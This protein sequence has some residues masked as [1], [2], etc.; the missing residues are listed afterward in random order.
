[1]VYVLSYLCLL[2]ATLSALTPILPPMYACCAPIHNTSRFID[3]N[4]PIQERFYGSIF[5]V[6]RITDLASTSL[7]NL[8]SDNTH[9]D[10]NT[11]D[12]T[13][14]NHVNVKLSN[15]DVGDVY[16]T[17]VNR[18]QSE[19]SDS[20]TDLN[21]ANRLPRH[22]NDLISE[23]EVTT[24][25]STIRA[26]RSLRT[27]HNHNHNNT[28]TLQHNKSGSGDLNGDISGAGGDENVF[29]DDTG[30]RN[31][32]STN[33]SHITGTSRKIQMYVSVTNRLLQILSDGTVNGT[34]DDSIYTILQ[35]IPVKVGQLRIQ[36]V[37]SCQYLCIDACGILYGSRDFNNE[38]C[39]FNEMIE[40]NHYNT[41]SSAKYSNKNRTMY[42]ALTKTGQPRKV[43]VKSTHL[44]KMAAYAR[45]LTKPVK[46]ERVDQLEI[47]ML[48]ILRTTHPHSPDLLE[49]ENSTQHPL[50]HHASHQLLCPSVDHTNGESNTAKNTKF[51]CRKRKKRKKKRRKPLHS[52]NRNRNG[53]DFVPKHRKQCSNKNPSSNISNSESPN[54]KSKEGIG[55]GINRTTTDSEIS[56]DNKHNN[57]N[58]NISSSSNISSSNSFSNISN[59]S[60][61]H[62]TTT[63]ETSIVASHHSNHSQQGKVGGFNK[64]RK[65]GT[66]KKHFVFTFDGEIHTN[67]DQYKNANKHRKCEEALQRQSAKTSNFHK[68][69]VDATKTKKRNVVHKN[70]NKHGIN[71]KSNV[72][73][74]KYTSSSQ[75]N[76]P[77][78]TASVQPFFGD[79]MVPLLSSTTLSPSTV[80]DEHDDDHDHEW[81]DETVTG[82][83]LTDLTS[84]DD[85]GSDL[86]TATTPQISLRH[87]TFITSSSNHASNHV[88][89]PQL[90]PQAPPPYNDLDEFDEFDDTSSFND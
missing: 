40:T 3:E 15:N 46:P 89:V 65:G 86:F 60:S 28:V 81:I 4:N 76:I 68:G 45:V 43:L 5:S 57:D 90:T 64:S 6:S 78:S 82:S 30:G 59:I 22:V 88:Q 49:L 20:V 58:M 44:G 63:N 73:A 56:N 74:C 51:R 10:F 31:E 53:E 33:L 34:N 41:Y 38:D 19:F 11:H 13:L 77:T 71:K 48:R 70:G 24:Q 2:A 27:R 47:E 36:G 17:K 32:R 50:R 35:R 87:H 7:N 80:V 52:N 79:G 18:K 69:E 42:L 66:N 39:V 8:T 62:N 54:Q 25:H 83:D 55:S 29:V 61:I 84:T 85:D 9:S 1:M 67:C 14:N 23:V 12:I 26:S 21:R 37:A 72:I 16:V 75:A